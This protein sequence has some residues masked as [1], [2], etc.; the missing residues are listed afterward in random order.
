MI[1]KNVLRVIA[2]ISF[3]L[4]GILSL[5]ASQLFKQV[6]ASTITQQ[7]FPEFLASEISELA[8]FYTFLIQF[9]VEKIT[10]YSVYFIGIGALLILIGFYLT[11][12]Y[13]KQPNKS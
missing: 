9:V 3:L 10:A 2:F 12:F 13:E 4:G 6:P 7:N 11:H 5:A 8:S 1:S